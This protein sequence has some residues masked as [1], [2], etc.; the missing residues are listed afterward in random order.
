MEDN[1]RPLLDRSTELLWAEQ[2]KGLKEDQ[3]R[4][5]ILIPLFRA[6]GYQGLDHYH[7]PTERGKDI[8]M[9]LP[10][11]T[12]GRENYAVVVKAGKINAK[13][14]GKGSAGEVATQ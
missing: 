6:M 13:A 1:E 5:Q 10:T 12:E 8:V 3:L 11:R 9:W 2:L 4:T 14:S 7:G